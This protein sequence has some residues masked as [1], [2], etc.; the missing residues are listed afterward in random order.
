MILYIEEREMDRAK[1]IICPL[2]ASPSPPSLLLTA[3][4]KRRN[5]VIWGGAGEGGRKNTK[6]CGRGLKVRE[7][8]VKRDIKSGVG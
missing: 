8:V 5:N 4:T 7:V 2:K 1:N 6:I 3:S